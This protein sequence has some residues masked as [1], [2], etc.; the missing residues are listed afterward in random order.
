[1][2]STDLDMDMEEEIHV[3]SKEEITLRDMDM[4][5]IEI[6]LLA[7]IVVHRKIHL[8]NLSETQLI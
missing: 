8:N 3:D 2:N 1:M 7:H 6:Y 5:S 4:E